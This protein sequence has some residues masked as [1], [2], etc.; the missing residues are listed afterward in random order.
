MTNISLDRQA[1]SA[2][3]IWFEKLSRDHQL[4]WRKNHNLELYTLYYIY[5]YMDNW[6]MVFNATFNN[7]LVIS[8]WSELLVEETG[9]P[10]EN[11]RLVTSHWQTLSHN[12][13]SSIPRYKQG[14]NSQLEWWY[15]LIA[16]VVVHPTTIWS[17]LPPQWPLGQLRPSNVMNVHV[18]NSYNVTL[19]YLISQKSN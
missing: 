18:L 15:A 1:S 2:S 8:W 13:V 11:H 6:F 19:Q 5:I 10:R 16:Q 4:S 7:I 9:V 12:V 3:I 14:L 17:W